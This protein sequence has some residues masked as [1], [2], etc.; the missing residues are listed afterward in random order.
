M[1]KIT[2]ANAADDSFKG[3]LA[4]GIF[5]FFI[6]DRFGY[7]SVGNRV[8]TGFIRLLPIRLTPRLASS[9]AVRLGYQNRIQ[10]PNRF[11]VDGRLKFG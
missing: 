7:L 8:F 4:W 10:S 9:Y 11:S 5:C 1:R 6:V 3:E 2:D